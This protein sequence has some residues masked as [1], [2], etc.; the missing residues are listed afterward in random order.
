MKRITMLL[1]ATAMLLPQSC[2]KENGSNEEP[3]AA[4]E[5]EYSGTLTADRTMSRRAWLW[6]ASWTRTHAP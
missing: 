5:Y 4:N 6:I 1:L 2:S 3:L